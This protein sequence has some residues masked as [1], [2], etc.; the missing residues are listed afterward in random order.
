MS[1]TLPALADLEIPRVREATVESP[2]RERI[3][4]CDGRQRVLLVGDAH[5]L[6]QI[7]G[8]VP[9]FERAGPRSSLAFDPSTITC[10]IVTCGGLCPGLNDVIRAIVMTLHHW[11]GVPK[12]LG[13]RYGYAGLRRDPPVAPL[14]LTP[15]LVARIHDDGGTVLGSSRGEQDLGEMAQTLERDGVSVLFAIGGD[16]TL[17]G[18]SALAQECRRRGLDISVIGIPKTID[19]DLMWIERSFGF[20]TAVEAARGAIAA[21][22]AEAQGAWNGVGL[23]KLMGRHSGF[24]AAEATLSN[25]DVNFCLVPE[26][27]VDLEGEHGFL[28]ALERRLAQRHHAVVVVAE[29]AADVLMPGEGPTA[30]DKSGNRKLDD[31]GVFLRDRTKAYFKARG[32]EMNIKY[33][34]PSYMIRGV[35]ANASDSSFCLALGQHAVHA[36]LHGCTDMLVGYWNQKFVHLP[37]KLATT[38]RHQI[39]PDGAFWHRVVLSTGQ[40]RMRA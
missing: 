39:D 27:P 19:N 6:A 12:I 24:I 28:G 4:W 26:V 36:G 3:P 2:L 37:M 40:P 15:Q 11:Y 16:G 32:V 10:G 8:D 33:I 1:K 23:V 7:E 29:G 30:L 22:H 14:E 21:A 17:R 18:A 5:K 25:S 9:S 34:D 38:G 35:Q 13:Y 31:V 20:L